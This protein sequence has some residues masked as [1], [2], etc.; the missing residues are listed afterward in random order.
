MDSWQFVLNCD[1]LHV[2]YQVL[3][4]GEEST[5]QRGLYGGFTLECQYTR[6]QDPASTYLINRAA[7]FRVPSLDDNCDQ[8]LSHFLLR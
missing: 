1:E 4:G 6:P 2:R 3:Y 8:P 7:I 5:P